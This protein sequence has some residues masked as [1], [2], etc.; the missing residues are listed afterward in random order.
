MGETP[1]M[2]EEMRKAKRFIV[3]HPRVEAILFVKRF[4][5]FWAGIPNPIEQFLAT[6]SWLAR[7]LILWATFSGVGALLGIA[8]LIRGH[9]PYTFP[10]AVFPIIFPF[11]YYITHTSLRYRH[12]IDP[13]ALLLTAIAVG[14]FVQSVSRPRSSTKP[15][16]SP[17]SLATSA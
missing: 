3:T 6:D 7:A 13:I 14:A 12:P 1:F 4:V 8:V 2:D 11:L 16:D 5:A 10:L 9:S 15:R 17:A